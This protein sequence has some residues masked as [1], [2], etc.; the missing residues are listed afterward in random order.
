MKAA[1]ID[2]K[3]EELEDGH[4]Q[5]LIPGDSRG[6]QAPDEKR[7]EM[8]ENNDP[9][10]VQGTEKKQCW[11]GRRIPNQ[12]SNLAPHVNVRWCNDEKERRK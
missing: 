11:Y 1:K 9:P 7:Q 8:I 10:E 4:Q 6:Q 2:A 3:E 5:P 12:L